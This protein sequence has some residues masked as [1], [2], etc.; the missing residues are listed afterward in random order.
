MAI[1]TVFSSLLSFGRIVAPMLLYLPLAVL[2]ADVARAELLLPQSKIRVS[3]VQW[4]PTKGV[5]EPWA[6]ISGEYTISDMGTVSLPVLGTVAT[7]NHD[8]AGLAADIA[9]QLRTKLGL[10][11]APEATV[12]IISYP[13]IYV[14]GDVAKPGVYEYRTG[15]TTIQ[16]F[17]SSGG[18]VRADSKSSLEVTR[19]LG[20]IR[21]SDDS[22][23][24][25]TARSER[26][27]A[28]MSDA[29]ELHFS[30]AVDET[31][32]FAAAIFDQEKT[33]FGARR[34]AMEQQAKS[35]TELRDF[36]EKEI[37]SLEE[38]L[39][40]VEANIKSSEAK[41]ATAAQLVQRGIATASRQMD[42]ERDLRADQGQRL[43]LETAVMRARQEFSKASRDLQALYDDRRSEA[44]VELQ[45]ERASM[46]QERLKRETNQNILLET[47]SANPSI[48]HPDDQRVTFHILRREDGKLNDFPASDTTILMPGDVVK[49]ARS[50]PKGELAIT[51]SNVIKG[52]G[53]P[54]SP[55][56]AQ[57]SQ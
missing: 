4:V 13:P 44:A 40:N 5:Y 24:R 26:L 15:L 11:S 52:D 33:I 30:Q 2:Q 48:G 19:L 34:R 7:N 14:V 49:V 29:T 53:A 42:T 21:A 36:L 35:L 25:S 6:G 1:K 16:A 27:Q 23:V 51:H 45:K 55:S 20:E 43:D 47:L 38:K 46:A 10:V 17:A 28:E 50:I 31:N 41:L 12:E 22:I 32:Q 8:N 54:A 9:E 57:A 3:I 39:T 37:S 18:E 56:Q